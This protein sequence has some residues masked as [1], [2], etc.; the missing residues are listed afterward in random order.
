MSGSLIPKK[1]LSYLDSQSLLK[2]KLNSGMVTL[3]IV[4]ECKTGQMGISG[5]EEIVSSTKLG[6]IFPSIIPEQC[7]SLDTRRNRQLPHLHLYLSFG[8]KLVEGPPQKN[9]LTEVAFPLKRIFAFSFFS[10]FS[11]K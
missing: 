2:K 4:L 9:S 10:K 6:A 1:V 11:Q 8:I 5:N 3:K 7:M